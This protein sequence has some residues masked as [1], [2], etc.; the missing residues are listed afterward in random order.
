MK[1]FNPWHNL[2]AGDDA[3]VVVNALIE[4]PMGSKVKYEL[5]KK[6]GLM[7]VDRVLYGAVYY[8]ANYGF[9]PQTYCGD[10]DP[11]DILV[12]C[13]EEVL[14]RTIMKAKVIGSMAMIDQGAEDDKI[15]AVFPGDPAFSQY[16]DISD[17]PA[18]QLAELRKFFEDYKKLEKKAVK[19]EDFYHRE[20]A[21]KVVRDA[22]ALYETNKDKL[23]EES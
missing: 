22:M 18:F 10:N 7:V 20:D 21:H 19:I 3:P 11:L 6:S 13:Q 17:L 1:H 4:I 16:E 8:P 12:L 9:I 14:P 23:R 5:D 2:D 15:I